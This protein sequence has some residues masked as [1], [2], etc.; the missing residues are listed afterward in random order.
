[1]YLPPEGQTVDEEE[2]EGHVEEPITVSAQRRFG[3]EVRL[4][5]PG[6][7]APLHV[8][9]TFSRTKPL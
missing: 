5:R 7:G 8:N 1:M 6:I 9:L 2:E 3:A 4:D